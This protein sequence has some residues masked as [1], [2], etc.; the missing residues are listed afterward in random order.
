MTHAAAPEL[1]EVVD[2]EVRYGAIRAIKGISFHV[3]EGEIVALIGPNH[4]EFALVVGGAV[5]AVRTIEHEDLEGAHPV[6]PN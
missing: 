1:L 5:Q 3:G 6:L 4:Q 2:L